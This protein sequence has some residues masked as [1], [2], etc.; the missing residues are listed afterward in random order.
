MSVSR[1]VFVTIA[2][3]CSRIG[4]GVDYPPLNGLHDTIGSCTTHLKMLDSIQKLRINIAASSC[5]RRL[6]VHNVYHNEYKVK[7]LEQSESSNKGK[8][9]L[10]F[11]R[12]FFDEELAAGGLDSAAPG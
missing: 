6:G 4:F 5:V 10:D 3:S 1:G 9:V 11:G 8:N 7:R 2:I 12:F